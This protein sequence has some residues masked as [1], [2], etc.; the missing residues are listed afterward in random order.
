MMLLGIIPLLKFNITF[1]KKE[2][3]QAA[4]EKVIQELRN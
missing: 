2:K 4:I 3:K 1:C